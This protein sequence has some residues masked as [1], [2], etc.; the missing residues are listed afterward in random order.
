MEPLPRTLKRL[1]APFLLFIL[2][3]TITLLTLRIQVARHIEA[4]VQPG[5]RNL[6]KTRHAQRARTGLFSINEIWKSR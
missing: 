3:M 6:L 5:I 4:L 2:G 1:D